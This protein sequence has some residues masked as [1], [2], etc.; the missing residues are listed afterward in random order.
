MLIQFNFRETQKTRW[1]IVLSIT[2][3]IKENN[4]ETVDFLKIDIEGA[5]VNIFK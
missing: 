4:I 1:Q 3:I 5:E 2:D